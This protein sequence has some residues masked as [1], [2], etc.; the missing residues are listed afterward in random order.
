MIYEE[1]HEDEGAIFGVARALRD[2][3]GKAFLLA[4][5]YPLITSEVLG[6]LRER[7][8]TPIWNGEPQPLCAV[9]NAAWL[10][11]IEERI[12]ARRYDLRT[13]GSREMIAEDELR[14]RFR[15]EPLMNVNTPEE[16]ERAQRFL[17]SR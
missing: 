8:A 13:L 16:W 5:D 3:N 6:Y 4:V 12:A 2:A 14:A 15:G 11:R 9:W 17:A 7:E 10:P 1:P